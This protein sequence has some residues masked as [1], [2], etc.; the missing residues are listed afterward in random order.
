[1]RFIDEA[2]IIIRSG[3]GGN[4]CVSFR[5]EKYIPRGGPNGGDGGDG[6]DVLLRA[7]KK[8][9]SLQDIRL[10]RIYQAKN[11]MPGLSSQCA[12][13]K[14][15]DLIIEV[16]L[17]TLVFQR[18]LHEEA[19]IA[20]FLNDGDTI[21]IARGG[22]GGKGNEHFKSSTQRSPRFAQTGEEGEELYLRLELKILADLAIIGLPN[23]GKSTLIATLSAA[24]PEIAPYPFTTRRPN[25]G[26]IIDEYDPDRRIILAD[27]P[28]L[29]EG[30]HLGIGLGHRFLKHIERTRFLLHLLSIE[31]I[32]L[33]DPWAGFTLINEELHC[34]NPELATRVQIPIISKTDLAPSEK[35]V[36]LKQKMKEDSMNIF[37]ICAHTGE[38]IEELERELWNAYDKFVNNSPILSRKEYVEEEIDSTEKYD[39]EI[40]YTKE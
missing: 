21:L 3:K 28:G 8:I 10:K 40:E 38:G 15:D 16:P 26:V 2:E 4:G 36:F 7:N 1:M 5:R 13:K 33:N 32:D 35:I 31:D 24:Q 19:V 18:S 23:A 12:G 9:T 20:D 11:G 17:G 27:I 22:R 30:A 39:I 6:G 14:G 25:L 29:I 34:F 37:F